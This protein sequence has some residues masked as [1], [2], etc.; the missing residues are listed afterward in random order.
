MLCERIA[1]MR[2]NTLKK[3]S[4]P[5]LPCS[6]HTLR[7]GAHSVEFK[8]ISVPVLKSAITE[9]D[10]WHRRRK[11]DVVSGMEGWAMLEG[12]NVSTTI[13]GT[14]PYFTCSVVKPRPSPPP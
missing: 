8:S 4:V 6:L 13:S 10:Q 12:L 2:K 1:R 3:A 14:K 5:G 7:V 9:Q 11:L